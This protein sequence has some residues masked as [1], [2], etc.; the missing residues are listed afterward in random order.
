MSYPS[1]LDIA[2]GLTNARVI[3]QFGR[4]ADVGANFTPICRSGL[5][6]TP[7][8]G[9]AVNLRVR[10]GGNPNDISGGSGAWSITLLGIDELGEPITDVIVTN[11]SSASAPSKK[12]FL[13]LTDAYVQS[14]G[15]YASQTAFSHDSTIN[16]ESTAGVLWATIPIGRADSEIGAYSVPINRSLFITRVRIQ[17]DASNKANIAMFRR[18]GILETAAPYSAMTLINEFPSLIGELQLDFDPPIKID[19]LSD[20]GFLAKS[21]TGIIS[22][23]TSFDGIETRP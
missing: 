12:T 17:A 20:V 10:A 2:R 22:V 8:V 9:D 15:T 7:Q 13:R 6:L 19:Q 18:P 4:N 23:S 14:S 3:R 5:Y 11:G 21:S 1:G 16:I